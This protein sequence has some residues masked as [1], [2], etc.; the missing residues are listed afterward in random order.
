VTLARR[1]VRAIAALAMLAAS[2]HAAGCTGETLDGG[3]SLD[4]P[5]AVD[6]AAR[7]GAPRGAP[8]LPATASAFAKA[9]AGRWLVCGH[10]ASS[11]SL[12]LARDGIDFTSDGQWSLLKSDGSGGYEHTVVDG[13]FGTYALLLDGTT[14]A[15]STTDTTPASAVSLRLDGP[16][17][18]LRVDFEVSPKRLLTRAPSEVDFVRLD[19]EVDEPVPY[20]SKEGEHCD[21]SLPCR[22]GLFCRPETLGG[23]AGVTSLCI[24][25]P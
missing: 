3:S 18:A 21:P 7:C 17:L 13:T 6:V 25:A 24:L 8:E 15:V 23:D 9:L 19:N 16:S 22:A 1:R 5:V 14:R 10:D 2:S 12:L 11:S 20:T 4:A